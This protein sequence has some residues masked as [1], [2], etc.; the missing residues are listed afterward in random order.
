MKCMNDRL[1]NAI[2]SSSELAY[3]VTEIKK[4]SSSNNDFIRW[5]YDL[6]LGE[7]HAVLNRFSQKDIEL[8]QWES[9]RSII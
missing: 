1:K 8:I 5:M 9:L 2:Y 3:Q 7:E 4:H 6:I